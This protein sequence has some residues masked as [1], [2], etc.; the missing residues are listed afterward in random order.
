MNAVQR[1]RLTKLRDFMRDGFNKTGRNGKLS[2]K[3]DFYLGH[4]AV[5]GFKEKECGTTACA[6]GWATTIFPRSLRLSI[7]DHI[8]KDE[9]CSDD[10]GVRHVQS[11][12]K[13]YDA[14]KEFFGIS[15]VE[16]DSIFNPSNY[17]EDV[18]FVTPRLV[19]GK[20]TEV[21]KIYK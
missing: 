21:L 19:A 8:D 6:L 10:I 4:W 11:G 18:F 14:A 5:P 3:E 16:T 12:E 2:Y 9:L 7:P 20:I 17:Y 1:K 13:G 15:M